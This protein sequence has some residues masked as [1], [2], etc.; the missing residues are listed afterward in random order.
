MPDEPE[1]LGL[2]ALELLQHSRRA[3]RSVDGEL[4]PLEEQD[5]A[6]WDRAAIDEGLGLLRAGGPYQLQA[7]IAAVHDEAPSAAETDWP[8]IVALYELLMRISDNPMVDLNHAVAVSM[9][10]GPQEGLALVEKLEAD[11]RVA[12]GQRL[13]MVR[14]HLLESAGE[15]AAA[16]AAYLAAA[17]RT[18]SLPQ[19]RYLNAR[20]ARLGR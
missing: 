16:R 2:L 11:Q 18:L 5:R 20:A 7:A 17:E 13:L 12:D 19:Q 15:R 14:A 10:R 8:Q 9:V 4:V 6:L 1:V 3:A